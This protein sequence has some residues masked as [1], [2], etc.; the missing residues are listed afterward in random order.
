MMPVRLIEQI[1]K[2]EGRT[3]CVV[4]VF[5]EP[6]LSQMSRTVRLGRTSEMT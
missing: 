2:I 1:T 4:L 5:R 3:V 6:P